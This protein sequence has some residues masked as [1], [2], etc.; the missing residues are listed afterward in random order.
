MANHNEQRDTDDTARI[1]RLIKL[2]DQAAYRSL[3]LEE[4]HA[5]LAIALRSNGSDSEEQPYQDDGDM[6]DLMAQYGGD[7]F[8]PLSDMP[9]QLKNREDIADPSDQ[10]KEE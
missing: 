10:H 7:T 5:Q 2:F 4:R 1:I 6:E 3:R 8:D 9:R